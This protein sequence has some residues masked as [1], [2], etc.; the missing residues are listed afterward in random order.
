MKVAV[1][2]AFACGQPREIPMR[3]FLFRRRE[4]GRTINP[5]LDLFPLRRQIR[6][7]LELVETR[8]QLGHLPRRGE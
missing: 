5:T 8:V 1:T 6:R 4:I 3:Q 7:G 2:D